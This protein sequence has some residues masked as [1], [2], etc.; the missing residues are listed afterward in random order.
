MLWYPEGITL[1]LVLDELY[2]V[3]NSLDVLN[4]ILGDLNIEFVLKSHYQINY[5]QGISAQVVLNVGSFC[6]VVSLNVE[7]LSD[8]LLTL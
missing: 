7:L 5:V 1:L 4:L 3:A 2:D 6:D 8:K